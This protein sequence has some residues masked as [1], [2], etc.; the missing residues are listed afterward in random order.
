MWKEP[1]VTETLTFN[2]NLQ[3]ESCLEQD[4]AEY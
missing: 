3:V 2:L 1:R 4:R